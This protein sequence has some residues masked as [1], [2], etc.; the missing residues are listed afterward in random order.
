MKEW[1]P[2]PD[3]NKVI[4]SESIDVPAEFLRTLLRGFGVVISEDGHAEF[5]IGNVHMW[6]KAIASLLDEAADLC[7]AAEPNV[8]KIARCLFAIRHF[9]VMPCIKS[10]IA[11]SSLPRYVWVPR[12]A[13]AYKTLLIFMLAQPLT[14]FEL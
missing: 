3:D 7:E 12:R 9:L 14:Q 11:K 2:Q 13:Y 1:V 4:K 6:M 5:N 8:K 10:V